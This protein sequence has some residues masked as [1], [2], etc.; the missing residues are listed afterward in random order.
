MVKIL[1]VEDEKQIVSF[2]RRGLMYKG[3]EVISAENGNEA[4][5][6]AQHAAPDLVILDIM[7]PDFDGFELCRYL[8]ATGNETL[9]ILMLTAKDDL[10]DKI[11]GLD[12]GADD[13]IT[14]PFDFEELVARIRAALRRVESLHQSNQRLEIGDLVIDS[15]A[16]EVWRAGEQV[17]LTRREYDLLEFLA[18]NA[19]HVL[20]KERIFERVWGY[21]NEAELEVIKVYINYLRSK[22]NVGGKPD[23]IHA[24]RGIGYVLRA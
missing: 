5:E 3:F 16:H 23:L 10:A 19:S 18:Q 8:R 1:V 12:S 24:V 17:E 15:N 22:L 20:S 9:P 21:D 6:K 14:K 7:L 4:I 11:T 2:L 13:Y